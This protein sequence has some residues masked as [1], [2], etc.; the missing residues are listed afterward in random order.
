MTGRIKAGEGTLIGNA[1][2]YYVAAELLK[3]G[4]V[5]ALALRN[6]PAFDILA[7]KG[8]RTVRVRVKTKSEE[9]TV[10]QRVIKKDGSI[11][12]DISREGDFRVLVNLTKETKNLQFYV[13]P[14]ALLNRWLVRDFNEWV[15]TPG[16]N[17]RPHDA[18]NK[19]RHM[20]FPRFR[21]RLLDYLHNWDVLWEQKR[22]LAEQRP[23]PPQEAPLRERVMLF[24]SQPPRP[25]INLRSE[26][27]SLSRRRAPSP[28]RWPY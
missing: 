5:A 15:S 16:K 24:H 4:I 6:A 22:R 2:E 11:F 14:T 18:T 25:C 21:D 17:D 19:K 12:R 20:G 1:G 13:V 9:Y 26:P 3:R 23:G 28:R 7:A 10:W 27:A 8:G